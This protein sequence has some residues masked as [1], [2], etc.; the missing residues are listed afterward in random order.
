MS[1][2]YIYAPYIGICDICFVCVFPAITPGGQWCLS[3]YT[4]DSDSNTCFKLISVKMNWHDMVDECNS[5]SPISHLVVIH[6]A[7]KQTAL[8][9]FIE[10]QH[11]I[12]RAFNREI[13]ID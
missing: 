1:L 7:A 13:F 12:S 11:I 2:L 4:Y 9:N 8:K 10:G 6:D 5:Y 3:G